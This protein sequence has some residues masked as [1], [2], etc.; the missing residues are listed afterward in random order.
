[1]LFREIQSGNKTAF[2][3]LFG[4]YYDRLVCFAKHYTRQAESAEDIT[5]ELFVRIWLMRT[6]LSAIMQPEVYLYISIKN[7][8]FNLSRAN[9]KRTAVLSPQPVEDSFDPPANDRANHMEDKELQRILDL[10]VGALPAQRRLIFRLVKEE[11]FKSAE[12]AS[13]LGISIRTVENQLYKAIKVLAE[14]ATAYLG[15]NPQARVARKQVPSGLSF[16][17]I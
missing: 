11:G 7:A 6:R 10:A 8:C 15:Y 16:F 9:R 14:S 12:V 4:L 5:S 13:V 3:E 2:D 17:L 1:M